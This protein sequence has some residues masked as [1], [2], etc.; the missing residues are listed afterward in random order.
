MAL[1]GV[2]SIYD[3]QTIR[4]N[5]LRQI[6]LVHPDRPQYKG[7]GVPGFSNA[8]IARLIIQ[9]YGRIM[10]YNWPTTMLENDRIVGTLLNGRITPIDQTQ[11][12]AQWNANQ[13]YDQFQ[14]SIWPS[15]SS[16][17]KEARYKFK[18]LS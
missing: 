11:T 18:G 6:K 12:E 4:R 16:L 9:A 10:R 1:L 13:F 17:K 7:E 5:F 14:N 2:N 3:Q 8:D 15:S